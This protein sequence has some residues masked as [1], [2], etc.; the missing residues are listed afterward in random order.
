MPDSCL[1]AHVCADYEI[2]PSQLRD[3]RE[4]CGSCELLRK[5]D[6]TI[7]QSSGHDPVSA[8]CDPIE[9]A[10]WHFGHE[11]MCSELCDQACGKFEDAKQ[12]SVGWAVYPYT[13]QSGYT[14]SGSLMI[15]KTVRVPKP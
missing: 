3:P 11:A 9:S 6:L 15:S 8:R 5:T 4:L 13:G 7:E 2:T 10:P 12:P 1:S 14:L